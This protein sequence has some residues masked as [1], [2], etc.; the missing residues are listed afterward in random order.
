MPQSPQLHWLPN[1]PEWRGK[2]RP[3]AAARAPLLADA[4]RLADA[5]L[6]FVQTNGLA[7]VARQH[8]HM[9]EPPDLAG[10]PV[11]LAVLASSTVHH[12]M[13]GIRVGGIRRGLWIDTYLADYGL[14]LQELLDTGSNLHAFKPTVVLLALDANH[15]SAGM[16]AGISGAEQQALFESLCCRLRTCWRAA[17]D[18]FRCQVIQQTFLAT[19]P[20]LIGSNEH[21]L[22]GSRAL[23]IA[24]LNAWLR[25]A[26]DDSG[27]DLL[28]IDVRVAHDGLDAWHDPGLWHRSKQ[29]IKLTAGPIYGDM[30]AR[31]IAA[32]RGLSRKCLVLDLDNTLWGGTIGDDGLEGIV[33]GQG[34][35]IGEAYLAVQTY[36]LELSRRG[37]ILAVNSKNDMANALEAFEKHPEMILHREHIT[38]FVA[39]W[40]DKPSNLRAIAD[41]LNIS[42]D[43]LVFLDDSPF[44]RDLVRRELPM[45]AVP[46][47]TDDPVS[48][49]P[50]IADAGYFEALVVTGEDRERTRLYQANRLREELKVIATDLD[51]YLA[52]LEMELLW[53]QFDEIGLQRTTQLINKTNQFNL[54]TRRYTE[55]EVRAVI[56]DPL[57]FGLQLRLVDRLG[58][59]GIISVIIGRLMGEGLLVETWL[60]SCRVLG[61]QVETATLNLVADHAKQLGARH[62]VGEYRPTVKNGMVRDHY[63]K[64]GFTLVTEH[65]GD[66][67]G[68]VLSVLDLAGFVPARTFIDVRPG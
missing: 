63:Q 68:S 52:G 21:R 42:L 24:R 6:D 46:E 31:L 41:E 48:F 43:S 37:V 49:I 38:S 55:T 62:L 25:E 67:D 36:A 7:E 28:A 22:G 14:Y 17:R 8:W 61:R 34:N 59:N 3:F 40:D 26:V 64:L 1:D 57:A 19:E 30:V 66:S 5:R 44:E 60:M 65:D 4:M 9:S 45:V 11:R 32:Q 51:G 50:A 20:P 39:N 16:H 29:E 56:E 27:V 54:T 33:L 12:L 53:R 58:D 2:L 23:I 15:I 47:V 13:A 10:K 35:P 18:A